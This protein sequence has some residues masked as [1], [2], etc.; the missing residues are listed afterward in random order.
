MVLKAQLVPPAA[1]A[2]VGLPR[3]TWGGRHRSQRMEIGGLETGTGRMFGSPEGG[4]VGFYPEK[5]IVID[6][7]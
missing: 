3:A 1:K 7:L 4:G 2:G 6:K 5:S